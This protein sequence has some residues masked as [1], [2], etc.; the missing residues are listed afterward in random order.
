MKTY[1][2]IEFLLV[3]VACF[4]GVSA[5][6][7][8]EVG[9][10]GGSIVCRDAQSNIIY[11]QMY[12]TWEFPEFS[13]HES[14]EVPAEILVEKAIARLRN[15]NPALVQ[16]IF[17]EVVKIKTEI[18]NSL[19]YGRIISLN[20]IFDSNHIFMPARCPDGSNIKPNYEQVINYSET[21]TIYVD[22]EIFSRFSETSK[23]A[24]YLHEGIYKTLRFECAENTS[25]HARKLTA[26]LIA[27]TDENILS[28]YFHLRTKNS[29]VLTVD[30]FIH[31]RLVEPFIE[32]VNSMNL[33]QIR[34]SL[35]NKTILWGKEFILKDLL[36][37][38]L[39]ENSITYLGIL[40][41]GEVILENWY[42]F[43]YN[44][45]GDKLST[46]VKLLDKN[47]VRQ[48]LSEEEAIPELNLTVSIH[49]RMILKAYSQIYKE[50]SK[51]KFDKKLQCRSLYNKNFFLTYYR[52]TEIG[53]KSLEIAKIL[54]LETNGKFDLKYL[55][56]PKNHDMYHLD[57]VS[58]IFFSAEMGDLELTEYILKTASYSEFV[59]KF[60]DTQYENHV[61]EEPNSDGTA[62]LR[63]TY[64]DTPSNRA[65]NL[66]NEKEM[67]KLLD[68][69]GIEASA[70]NSTCVEKVC[71]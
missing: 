10:G 17:D 46:A 47:M 67:K 42:K 35:N 5:L 70:M 63:C 12:D 30:D 37:E 62:L 8:R 57:E 53:N 14:N 29:R 18:S 24:A 54:V 69:Y 22:G 7:D 71:R 19:N 3:L 26:M 40:N 20:T 66:I 16:I 13:I 48:I 65:D 21:G 28:E 52:L 44:F 2:Q 6:A 59:I 1:K 45:N 9:N 58:P 51:N 41:E 38:L 31:Q 36:K 15:L 23:A 55:F 32:A 34:H 61:F 43:I 68:K 39:D 33:K 64:F 56:N 25:E 4:T 27:N 11:A 49:P 50:C 60:P